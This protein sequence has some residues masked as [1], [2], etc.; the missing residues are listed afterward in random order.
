MELALG[1]GPLSEVADDDLVGFLVFDGEADVRRIE[2]DINDRIDDATTFAD[3]SPE[4]P[5]EWLLTD[6]YRES[7]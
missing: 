6:V 5:P 3:A 4:P 2:K 1:H 7:S